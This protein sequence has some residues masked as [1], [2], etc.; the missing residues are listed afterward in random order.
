MLADYKES[1][2]AREKGVRYT[3]SSGASFFIRR[4]GMA[5]WKQAMKEASE[6]IIGKSYSFDYIDPETDEKILCKAVADY[7]VSG[8]SNL[9]DPDGEEIIYSLSN[10]KNVFEADG[11]P[12]YSL[13]LEL[14]NAAHEAD[15]FLDVLVREE[16]DYIK[17]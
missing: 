11:L 15:R 7:L 12:Y 9:K 2:K 10:A 5:A 4:A 17:K 6:E 16:V 3:I 14:V 13:A 1:Q 8:W